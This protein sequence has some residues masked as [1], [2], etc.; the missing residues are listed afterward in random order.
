MHCH[1]NTWLL[2]IFAEQTVPMLC[3][4][5][6]DRAFPSP[7]QSLLCL[8]LANLCLCF[9]LPCFAAA[10]D[11]GALPLLIGAMPLTCAA[12]QIIA[13]PLRSVS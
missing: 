13:T 8:R 9:A 4:A 1:R 3:A 10:T 11:R 2:L 12:W 5:L 7:C 6:L